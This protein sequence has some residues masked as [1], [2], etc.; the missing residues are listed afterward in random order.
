MPSAARST[1]CSATPWQALPNGPV[2]CAWGVLMM[3]AWNDRGFLATMTDATMD[4][5]NPGANQAPPH[6]TWGRH[7][8]ANERLSPWFDDITIEHREMDWPFGSVE[9]GMELYREGSPR[10]T[11]LDDNVGPRREAL[12]TAL[13]EHLEAHADASGQIESTTGYSLVSARGR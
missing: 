5:V 7:E 1:P 10:H 3:T 9:E 4:A 2:C 8:V 13:R 6:M 11:W 12:W